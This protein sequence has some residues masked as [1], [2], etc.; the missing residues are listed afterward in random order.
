MMDVVRTSLGWSLCVRPARREDANAVERLGARV[1]DPESAI[2][3]RN[4]VLE[5]GLPTTAESKSVAATYYLAAE[6]E[7]APLVGMIGFFRLRWIGPQNGFL[8]WFAVEPEHQRAGV[9]TAL[10]EFLLNR[11]PSLQVRHLLV[12]T[13][14]EGSSAVRFYERN[15]FVRVSTIDDYW[16]D[17][18]ALLLYRRTL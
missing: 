18:S 6:T 14:G 7:G 15:G 16:H 12:E 13:S 9:G 1:F 2:A 5:H 10:L 3:M 11:L 4:A 8:G 17:G